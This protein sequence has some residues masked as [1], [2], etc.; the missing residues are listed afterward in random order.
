MPDGKTAATRTGKPPPLLS[1]FGSEP[2]PAA[3]SHQ[4]SRIRAKDT[5]PEL[6]LR[7]ELW[8]LGARFRVHVKDLP[9]RPDIANRR[10]KV[11]VFVDGCFWHGCP[12]HFHAP[13][14][15]T[16]FWVEKVRRNQV[17]R[18]KILLQ[19]EGW[20][21]FQCFEC[22]VKSSSSRLAQEILA[23]MQRKVSH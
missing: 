23:R 2:V 1:Y 21:V 7:R 18:E 15:R 12:R 10:A 11:V 9:G 16:T 22:T 19:Y 5:T 8:R 20:N 14:T 3:R 6:L 17:R 13:R 4:M